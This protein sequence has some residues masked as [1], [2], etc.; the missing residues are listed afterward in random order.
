MLSPKKS[1]DTD[2]TAKV[3]T[4][5]VFNHQ[6]VPREFFIGS[7]WFRWE[8]QGTLTLTESQI[9][10]DDFKQQRGYFAIAEVK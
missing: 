1:D 4:F 10:S 7:A 5:F 6:N 9:N 3:K 8:P 2:N